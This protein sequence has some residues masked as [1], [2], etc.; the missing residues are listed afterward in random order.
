MP[1]R[2]LVVK[3]A[4]IGDLLTATPALRAVRRRFP[5]A[6]VDVLAP[7]HSAEVLRGLSSID[8][9]ILF[10]KSQYD[11]PW[12]ALRPAPL[13]AAL[14]LA[15]RLRSRRYDAI[16]LLHHL[17]TRW[18]SLKYA[19]LTLAI[20]APRRYGLDNG[21]GRAWF[22][23]DRA[24]DQGFGGAHEVDYW[25]RVAS[26]LGASASGLR[27]EVALSPSDE[28]VASRLLPPDSRPTVAIHAGSGAFGIARRWP[29]AGFA[30]VANSLADRHDARIVLVGGPEEVGLCRE[31]AALLRR[32]ALVLA[33][34]TTLKETA[35]LL[36]RTDLFI[37]NDS[38]LMNLAVAVDTR[39]LAVFGL[40]N[41]R[42]WGPYGYQEWPAPADAHRP[43][44]HLVV[45]VDLPCSPCF[46]HGHSTGS[47]FG[48]PTRDCLRLVT[49]DVV[50]SAAEA[51]LRER[52]ASSVGW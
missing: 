34:Q 38:G 43:L 28:E 12:Q 42:A 27:P 8:G 37:G 13:I 29:V 48:C 6:T 10:R 45:R 7:P 47:R 20:G 5:S 50:L 31:L 49:P 4:D 17:V 16:L 52:H 30:T 9:L 32:P 2:I 35:A 23:T 11:S 39:V 22:L 21:L 15:A 41:H 3:L 19:L 44:R 1:E 26:L 18:G 40:S 36:R 33:G 24:I 46:Y 51:L 14:R 25:L